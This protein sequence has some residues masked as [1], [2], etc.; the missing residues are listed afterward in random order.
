MAA[1]NNVDSVIYRIIDRAAKW[2]PLLGV[3]AVPDLEVPSIPGSDW[4]S[5][6][7][8]VAAI[9]SELRKLFKSKYSPSPERLYRIAVDLLEHNT[10]YEFNVDFTRNPSLEE[11]EIGIPRK[12]VIDVSKC[13]LQFWNRHQNNMQEAKE[14]KEEAMKPK[15]E[16][17]AA[18]EQCDMKAQE[19]Y[20]P[21]NLEEYIQKELR[22]QQPSFKKRLVNRG[23]KAISKV[24]VRKVCRKLTRGTQTLMTNLLAE[25]ISSQD[26]G[27][28]KAIGLF[29]SSD[30]GRGFIAGALVVALEALPLP[31]ALGE[32][33]E[34]IK[35]ALTEEL[36]VVAFDEASAPLEKVAGLFLPM[37]QQAL[38]PLL[39]SSN[40]DPKK[41]K[42]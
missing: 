5:R 17:A 40:Q 18:E 38:M 13:I 8:N 34:E 15:Y 24:V 4:M 39:A 31:L 28:K 27:I 29:L 35:D 20:I 1:I 42:A 12:A 16:K 41:L 26:P 3:H 14:A 2:D 30:L 10:G 32:N 11:I 36:S 7:D 23:K 6:Q 9:E 22:A 37:A 33:A 19:T 25:S 21:P